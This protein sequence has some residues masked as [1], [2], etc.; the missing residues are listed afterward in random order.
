[1]NGSWMLIVGALALFGA[2]F[3]LMGALTGPRVRRRHL[4]A[5]LAGPTEA[6]KRSQMAALGVRAT[7]LDVGEPPGVCRGIVRIGSGTMLD[8]RATPPK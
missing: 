6:S 4:A 2:L 3:L 7:A 5:E 1:M 8:V